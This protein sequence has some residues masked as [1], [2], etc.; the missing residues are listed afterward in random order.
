MK[1]LTNHLDFNSMKNNKA[2][3]YDHFYDLHRKYKLIASD[4]T[5]IRTGGVNA[6]KDEMNDELI[7][8][9]DAWMEE[10]PCSKEIGYI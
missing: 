7:R 8:K 4:S 3:T 2:V 5:H 1:F 9:F 10:Q 6:Y